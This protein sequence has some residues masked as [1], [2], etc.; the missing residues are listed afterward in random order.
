[1]ILV[2]NTWL[3]VYPRPTEICITKDQ[4]LLVMNSE[5][6]LLKKNIG[7]DPIQAH[8]VIQ[9]PMQYYNIFTRLYIT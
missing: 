7:Y 8:Q 3:E 1:M 4:N 5:N 9:L 2:D 6:P